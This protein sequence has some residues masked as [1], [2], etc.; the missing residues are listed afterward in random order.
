MLGGPSMR[1]DVRFT[2]FSAALAHDSSYTILFHSFAYSL[3]VDLPIVFHSITYHI[4]IG[5]VVV[6][7]HTISTDKL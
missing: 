3:L 4:L 5:L 2:R 1:R 6:L 7:N